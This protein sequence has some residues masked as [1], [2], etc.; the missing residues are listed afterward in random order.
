MDAS[1]RLSLRLLLA[2][3]IARAPA[4]ADVLLSAFAAAAAAPSCAVPFPG[5][6]LAGDGRCAA[7]RALVQG[8]PPLPE[9]LR[10]LEAPGGGAAAPGLSDAQLRLLQWLLLQLAPQRGTLAPAPPAAAAAA[11]GAA[12][13]RTRH[14]AA[15]EAVLRVA[16]RPERERLA[17]GWREEDWRDGGD[18]PGSA[19]AARGQHSGGVSGSGSG[20][21]G[22]HGGCSAAAAAAPPPPP[23]LYV[24]HGTPFRRLHAILHQ[25]LLNAS[26]TR[27]AANGALFGDG[28]YTARDL[29]T[30]WLFAPPDAGWAGSGL[31]A[32]L[33]CA[34]LCRVGAAAAARIAGARAAGELPESYCVVPHPSDIR[35]E[36]VCIW[37]DA[38]GAA[39]GAGED[40]A[41]AAGAAGAAA[42]GGDGPAAGAPPP[43]ESGGGTR[44]R[45]PVAAELPDRAPQQQQQ[46]RRPGARAP[47]P[48]RRLD[49]CGLV[50]AAYVAVLLALGAWRAWRSALRVL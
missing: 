20:S 13:P 2:D 21:G 10:R 40:A 44:R 12:A 45:A 31:G 26:G 38:P 7:A 5:H 50:T 43:P 18:A 22:G 41:G 29:A 25:G 4:A 9:L 19:A 37:A 46:Q 49:A 15:C 1:E 11:T 14:L 47:R 24:W 30:A 8:L 28:I 42:A 6:L 32:R 36:F 17:P 34:L 16:A 3:A 39:A 48:W 23:P 35:V 33:R 27:G